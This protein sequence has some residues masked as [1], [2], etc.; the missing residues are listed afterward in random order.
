MSTPLCCARPAVQVKYRSLFTIPA[1]DI[2]RYVGKFVE[3][4]VVPLVG[5]L[6]GA[7]SQGGGLAT[8][9]H[10]M[11]ASNQ[12]NVVRAMKVH[13]DTRFYTLAEFERD[14]DEL[15]LLDALPDTVH[16]LT[17]TN[18]TWRHQKVKG[19]PPATALAEQTRAL[20][21]VLDSWAGGLR[22]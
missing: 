6:R 13:P 20:R 15:Q 22:K 10:L 19:R 5:P 3:H 9:L 18:H 2:F 4:V 8:R 16:Q 12:Q 1:G 17:G 14:W 11:W 21:A 7:G